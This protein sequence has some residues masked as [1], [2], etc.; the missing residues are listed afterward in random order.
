[1]R[2]NKLGVESPVNNFVSAALEIKEKQ[3]PTNKSKSSFFI[4]ME[5]K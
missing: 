2:E 5:F 1:M 4:E 3:Q